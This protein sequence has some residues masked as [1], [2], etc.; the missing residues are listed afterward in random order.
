MSNE[1]KK[2]WSVAYQESV[3]KIAE[4][5][6]S[7]GI[8][9]AR[10]QIVEFEFVQLNDISLGCNPLEDKE[11]I[12]EG[13]DA[14]IEKHGE[15]KMLEVMLRWYE[16][17]IE[18]PKPEPRDWDAEIEEDLKAIKNWKPPTGID[19]EYWNI[20]SRLLR[21]PTAEKMDSQAK[22]VVKDFEALAAHGAPENRDFSAAFAKHA[23][24]I[25]EYRLARESTIKSACSDILDKGLSASIDSVAS[26]WVYLRAT[27][28]FARDELQSPTEMYVSQ[29]QI[30]IEQFGII[31]VENLFV[32]RLIAVVETM[33]SPMLIPASVPRGRPVSDELLAAFK[34]L[35][36]IKPFDT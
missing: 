26:A 8:G 36:S 18:K 35:N 24:A 3:V 33:H 23:A 4:L 25:E 22:R 10:A 20:T 21:K 5:L 19:K 15:E 16:A 2:P 12:S 13:I 30:M 17:K 6:R 9:V 34:E 1:P 7:G 11:K 31:P 29:I 14:L 27:R 32:D 28:S